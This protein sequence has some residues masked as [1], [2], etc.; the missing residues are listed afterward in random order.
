[1]RFLAAY[2]Q[3]PSLRWGHALERALQHSLAKVAL[4]ARGE[5]VDLHLRYRQALA[6]GT[7]TGE[8]TQVVPRTTPR[9]G[10]W[11]PAATPTGHSEQILDA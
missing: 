3:A 7:G 2:E 9:Y 1:M 5:Q 4:A 6:P 10:C 8:V 11:R